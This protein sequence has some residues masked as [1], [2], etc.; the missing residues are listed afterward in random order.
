[1]SRSTRSGRCS[2]AA[3]SA[4]GP[5][6]AIHTSR[7]RASKASARVLAASSVVLD[8]EDAELPRRRRRLLCVLRGRVRRP[9]GRRGDALVRR[10]GHALVRRD[11]QAHDE[12]CCLARAPGSSL[13]CSRRG[14]RPDRGR[15][16][17][18][19]RGR[20]A[21]DRGRDPPDGTAR[22]PGAAPPSD[23][24]PV[25][26]DAQL[27]LVAALLDRHPDVAPEVVYLQRW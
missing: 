4:R 22:R 23:P 17:A 14:G 19:S 9:D 21:P 7:P 12:L 8:D 15:W 16:S 13:R 18:R 10:R 24:D 1:M 20:R 3:L 6:L 27:H 5:S 11:G 2:A 25:V 26:A